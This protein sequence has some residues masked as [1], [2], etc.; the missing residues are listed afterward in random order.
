MGMAC[1]L[2]ALALWFCDS[3]DKWFRHWTH[4]GFRPNCWRGLCEWFRAEWWREL[5]RWFGP[6]W[7]RGLCEWFCER[8]REFFYG[9]IRKIFCG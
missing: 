8:P 4:G 9:G 5:C 3:F 7:W 6:N 1:I 2:W